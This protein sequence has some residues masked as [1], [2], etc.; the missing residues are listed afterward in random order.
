MRDSNRTQSSSR[1]PSPAWSW[2]GLRRHPP[3]RRDYRAN[4]YAEPARLP[5]YG[6]GHLLRAQRRNLQAEHYG[7]L[8]FADPDQ[9]AANTPVFWR[10]DLLAGALR[11]KLTPVTEADDETEP[12][13]DTIILS[14]LKTRRILFET[15]DGARHILLNGP[16]FWI[17]LYALNR[18]PVGDHAKIDL[19]FDGTDY[20]KRRLDTAAQL[21]ALHRADGG[22]LSLIGRRRNTRPLSTALKAY[23]IIHGFERPAGTLRDVAEMIVGPARMAS[24]WGRNDRAIKAQA[25][26]ALAKGERFV[27]GDYRRLL[28]QK[29]L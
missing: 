22:R 15:V 18:A 7:L 10:P 2:E 6:G 1:R 11:V 12:S 4:L 21:L 9:S 23:D 29:V 5:L 20:M 13:P 14:A 8:T 24:D 16:R 19:R 28:T 26:R 17:Q 3:Y 25:R 27:R